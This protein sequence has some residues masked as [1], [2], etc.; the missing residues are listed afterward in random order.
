MSIY[1]QAIMWIVYVFIFV[2]LLMNAI[3][4]SYLWKIFEVGKLKVSRVTR[5]TSVIGLILFALIM[6]GPTIV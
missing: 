3:N 4:P 6:T 5:I 2:N 1:I